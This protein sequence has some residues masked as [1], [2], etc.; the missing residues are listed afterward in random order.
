MAKLLAPIALGSFP[1]DGKNIFVAL[2]PVGVPLPNAE[3]KNLAGA[4]G[5]LENQLGQVSTEG[6]CSSDS[7]RYLTR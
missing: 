3:N 2:I 6:L 1:L 7:Q 5:V 4:E